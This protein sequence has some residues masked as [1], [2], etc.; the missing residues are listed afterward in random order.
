[1]LVEHRVQT[2]AQISDAL[3]LNP[4]DIESICGTDRG[5][6]D[7]KVVPFTLKSRFAGG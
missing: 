5:F 7:N 6:L 4:T 3:K 1:M 2:R